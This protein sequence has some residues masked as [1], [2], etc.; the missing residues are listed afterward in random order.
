MKHHEGDN[1]LSHRG[2]DT[3]VKKRYFHPHIK[4]QTLRLKKLF[5]PPYR[6]PDNEGLTY[7]WGNLL[8][9]EGVRLPIVD[10]EELALAARYDALHLYGPGLLQHNMSTHLYKI[11][12]FNIYNMVYTLIGVKQQ[13]LKDLKW[14]IKEGEFFIQGQPYLNWVQ[15]LFKFNM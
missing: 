4:S 1:S 14:L 10:V 11:A 12:C 7:R 8:Q 6:G 15:V 5:Q 2:P 3:E 9:Q 13:H